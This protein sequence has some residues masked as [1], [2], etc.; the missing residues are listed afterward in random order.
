MMLLGWGAKSHVMGPLRENT[1]KSGEWLLDAQSDTLWAC[2]RGAEEGER[3][4]GAFVR[5]SQEGYVGLA[6]DQGFKN[7]LGSAMRAC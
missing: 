6:G 2:P 4:E 7:N 5:G 3:W 1:V